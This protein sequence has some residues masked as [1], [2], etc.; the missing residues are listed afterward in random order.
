MVFS[1][2]LMVP[3][4]DAVDALRELCIE[5]PDFVLEQTFD[6]LKAS[7]S[8]WDEVE[9]EVD[10]DTSVKLSKPTEQTA[11]DAANANH[12]RHEV[13]PSLSLSL[14]TDERLWVALTFGPYR[15][16][17]RER[18]PEAQRAKDSPTNFLENYY[19]CGGRNF[20]RSNALARLWWLGELSTFD[21]AADTAFT[22]YLV[23]R[24]EIY[25]AVIDRPKLFVSSDVRLAVLAASR[26]FFDSS[27]IGWDKELFRQ[28]MKELDF[29][30]G[31]KMLNAISS[32]RLQAITHG[33]F[34]RF[35]SERRPPGE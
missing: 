5:Q 13:L 6:S 14:A 20:R 12:V 1:R 2:T 18:F 3:T 17:V 30:A 31:R 22:A 29:L 10:N 11:M 34:E 27:G 7:I 15:E 19:L 24:Q 35:H 26:E 32:S 4:Y 21:G 16:Y 28:V 9:L 23:K 33:L 25:S 8:A